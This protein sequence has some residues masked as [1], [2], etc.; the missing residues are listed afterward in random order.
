M[1]ITGNAGSALTEG[2]RRDMRPV[3][4]PGYRVAAAPILTV[5]YVMEFGIGFVVGLLLSS[6]GKW[7]R[8]WLKAKL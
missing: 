8:K 1:H 3:G 4:I 2:R 6:F 7:F 5:R